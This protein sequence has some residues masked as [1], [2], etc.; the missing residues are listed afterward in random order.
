MKITSSPLLQVTFAQGDTA[1]ASF[2]LFRMNQ[3]GAEDAELVAVF[4][5]RGL[6][7]NMNSTYASSMDVDVQDDRVLM[8]VLVPNNGIAAF[9]LTF[10]GDT[11][12]VADGTWNFSSTDFNTLGQ[13]DSITEVNGLTIYATN[14]GMINISEDAQVFEGANYH[15]WTVP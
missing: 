10:H 11:S 8:F 4:P 15:T 6:G 12:I 2:Q 14:E 9:E 5:E 7:T 1:A 13:L 3:T